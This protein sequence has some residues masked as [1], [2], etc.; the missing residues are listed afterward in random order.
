MTSGTF[1]LVF[2]MFISILLLSVGFFYILGLII[3]MLEKQTELL[4]K[5][6]RLKKKQMKVKK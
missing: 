2:W 4:E 5:L 3:G 6:Y 1:L